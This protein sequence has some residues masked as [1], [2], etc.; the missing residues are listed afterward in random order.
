MDGH[1]AAPAAV[2]A[3]G[4]ELAHEVLEGEASLLEDACFSVLREH[5]V[6]WGEGRCG[7][8]AD[9]FLSGGDLDGIAC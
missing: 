8:D 2:F 9:A 5:H 3:V 1:V 6:V 7:P 4:E